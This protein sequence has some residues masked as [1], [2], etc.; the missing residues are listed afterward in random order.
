V[1]RLHDASAWQWQDKDGFRPLLTENEI[2]N[3]SIR[4]GTLTDEER[5]IIESHAAITHGMLSKLPFP[6]KFKNVPFLAASHHERLDGTGYPQG[7]REDQLP[8]QARI[9]ALADIFEAL[10]ATDR[11]YRQGNTL[12]DVIRI[13]AHMAQ[14]HH[15]DADLFDL[16]L[17]EKIHLDY[18][19]RELSDWQRE[20]P[21]I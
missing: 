16:F 4:S 3:L 11:P 8:I 20:E 14:D 7:L 10:T 2:Y 12:N 18:A 19:A 15:I 13:M 6:K 1:D 17:Q 5:A 21:E 9:L